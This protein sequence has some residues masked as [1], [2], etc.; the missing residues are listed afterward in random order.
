MRYQ[1]GS[2]FR[3]ALETRLRDQSLASGLPLDGELPYD[4]LKSLRHLF[5]A[6]SASLL[7]RDLF[8]YDVVHD[9]LLF[10]CWFGWNDHPH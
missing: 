4:G 1:S 3:R 10:L 2:A 5:L 8:I 9:R 7:F 6:G